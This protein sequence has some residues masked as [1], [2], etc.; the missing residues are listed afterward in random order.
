MLAAPLTQRH[1]YD[2]V[3]A[4]FDTMDSAAGLV[5]V[6][7][8]HGSVADRLPEQADAA[9]PIAPDRAQ[10]ARL[11]YL[12]LGDWHG[13]LRIDERTWY[14][15]T[16]EPDRFRGN[17]P[18]YALFVEVASPGAPPQVRQLEV[19]KYRWSHWVERLDLASDAEDLGHRLAGLQAG[20]VLRLELHGALSLARWDA[21][22]RDV[23][24][25]AARVRAL[26]ADSAGL[27][28]EPDAADL[29]ALSVDGYVGA[30]AARLQ[31]MQGDGAQASAARVA[32]RLLLQYQRE[33]A[34][35]AS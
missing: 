26:V 7:L 30:A 33:L 14:A 22:R 4:A 1:T 23:E 19:G 10:R 24:R 13:C 9:N 27:V 12:A 18:G 20:D 8:A 31:A 16:P 35:G 15:G 34:E 25:A 2:D 11:D 28:L 32:L 3:T 17:T 29:A 5:R 21:L 6:G